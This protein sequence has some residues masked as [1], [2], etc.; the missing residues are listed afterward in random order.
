MSIESEF[1][2]NLSF[3][4]LG[5]MLGT[6]FCASERKRNYRGVSTTRKKATPVHV[7]RTKS[8]GRV[9]HD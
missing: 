1:M 9:K 2:F 4:F 8:I 5:M 7:I 3:M 6:A